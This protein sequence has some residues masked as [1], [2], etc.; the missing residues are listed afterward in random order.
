MRWKPLDVTRLP[1]ILCGPILRRVDASSVTVWVALHRKAASEDTRDVQLDVFHRK[2]KLP[3][4]SGKLKPTRIGDVYVASVQATGNGLLSSSNYIYRLSFGVEVIFG[5]PRGESEGPATGEPTQLKPFDYDEFPDSDPTAPDP[6]SPA[7][8]EPEPPPDPEDVEDY[9]FQFMPKDPHAVR[10]A[11]ASCRKPDGEGMDALALLQDAIDAGK[12]KKPHL[13]ILTGDQIYADGVAAPLLLMIMDAANKLL[14]GAPES[15]DP[16]EG[17]VAVDMLPLRRVSLLKTA[18]IEHSYS[19]GSHLVTFAEYFLMYLFAW[20]EVLWSDADVPLPTMIPA[21]FTKLGAY[22]RYDGPPDGD[23]WAAQLSPL[24]AFRRSLPKVR[25]LLQTTPTLM[26]FDDHDVTD[27]WRINAQWIGEVLKTK[28]GSRIQLNALLA[29]ILNQAAGNDP[30]Q[31]N[32]LI[33]KLFAGAAPTQWRHDLGAKLGWDQTGALKQ[34]AIDFHYTIKLPAV[35]V[36]VLDTRT[37]RGYPNGP[38]PYPTLIDGPDI[39]RQIG[40]SGDTR[41]LLLVSPAPLWGYATVELLQAVLAAHPYLDKSLTWV[42]DIEAWARIDDLDSNLNRDAEAWGLV[43][44][45]RRALVEAILTNWKNAEFVLVLSGDVH[46]GFSAEVRVHRPAVKRFVQLTSSATHNQEGKAK[47]AAYPNAQLIGDVLDFGTTSSQFFYVVEYHRH[48]KSLEGVSEAVADSFAKWLSVM[49]SGDPSSYEK[50]AP[51]N[52][53]GVVRF[54]GTNV[55]HRVY[56][57]NW[58]D[59]TTALEWVV[60]TK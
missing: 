20:S 56:T 10:I 6:E 37:R 60:P 54:D 29:Y 57:V 8:P 53:C 39:A 9:A 40:S 43:P 42:I 52:N 19:P 18:G 27:D 48:N 7:E 23:T 50:S 12:E 36:V 55:I 2:T 14:A 31:F 35:Y 24:N 33:A 28:L 3:I 16:I 15:K 41:P 34:S 58:Q 51:Y 1:R 32:P 49:Y 5:Y 25:R 46:Y 17:G 44:E 30:A 47:F 26:I 45:A 22:R 38:D 4:L 11:H 59:R 13:L 21:V